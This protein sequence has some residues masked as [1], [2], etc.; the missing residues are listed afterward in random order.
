MEIRLPGPDTFR[1][2]AAENLVRS[3]RVNF[4]VDKN[5]SVEMGLISGLGAQSRIFANGLAV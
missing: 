3:N 5:I 1:T 2:F 4:F